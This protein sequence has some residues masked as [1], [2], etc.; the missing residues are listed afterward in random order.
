[1]QIGWIREILETLAARSR[2]FTF[3]GEV[4]HTGSLTARAT[5]P[6]VTA[7][8]PLASTRGALY[9][10]GWGADSRAAIGSPPRT[11]G[12]ASPPFRDLGH[13]RQPLRPHARWF[14]HHGRTS[15]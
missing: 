2:I 15:N 12:Y 11:N 3:V 7:V 10:G 4:R 8:E 13:P 1:V 14:P 5:S 9:A 6:I